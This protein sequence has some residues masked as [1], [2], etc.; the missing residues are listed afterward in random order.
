LSEGEIIK[1]TSKGQITIPAKIR[2]ALSLD[3]DSYLY[4]ARA[5]RLIVM[6]KVDELSLDEIS[7]VLEAVAEDRGVTR[8]F[9][10]E[11]AEKARERLMEERRALAQSPGE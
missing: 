8:E 6:R 3:R 9:L 7:A 2:R 4:L 11:E 5:G 10:F 1:V